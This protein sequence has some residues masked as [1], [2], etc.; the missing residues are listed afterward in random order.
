ML[1][2]GELLNSEVLRETSTNGKGISTVHFKRDVLT[3]T[4][5]ATGSTLR[6]GSNY[7]MS[8]F[9]CRVFLSSTLFVNY[10]ESGSFWLQRL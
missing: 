4:R 9:L 5:Y 3:L 10:S 6:D 1:Y 2:S 7:E 8:S